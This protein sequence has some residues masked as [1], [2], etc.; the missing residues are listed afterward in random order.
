MTLLLQ[1]SLPQQYVYQRSQD[2]RTVTSGSLVTP[3]A[4][5]QQQSVGG[6][7]DGGYR[8]L[9]CLESVGVAA[10]ALAVLLVCRPTQT[11]SDCGSTPRQSLRASQ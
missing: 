5:Y 9:N 2:Y 1:I 6:E 3:I 7:L 4:I 8:H 10:G 11:A